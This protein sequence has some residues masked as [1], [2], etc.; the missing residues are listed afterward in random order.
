MDFQS[1]DR[2][3][4]PVVKLRPPCLDDELVPEQVGDGWE[5]VRSAARLSVCLKNQTNTH[6]FAETVIFEEPLMHHV[7][8]L[9]HCAYYVLKF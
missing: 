4:N 1:E 7:T 6:F 2:T 3:D 5:I 8:R 9:S